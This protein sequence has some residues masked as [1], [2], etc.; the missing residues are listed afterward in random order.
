MDTT[1]KK[2]NKQ[3]VRDLNH[4]G[5]KVKEPEAVAVSTT[6]VEETVIAA[7]VESTDPTPPT[8]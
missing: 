2:M 4:Y 3:G 7:T 5:P 1:V 8:A 6:L